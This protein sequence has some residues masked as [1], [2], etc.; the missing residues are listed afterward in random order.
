MRQ[1]VAVLTASL[2]ECTGLLRGCVAHA[3]NHIK[4]KIC[5]VT[6]GRLYPKW[7]DTVLEERH[8]EVGAE[9]VL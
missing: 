5:F 9:S 3:F 1:P 8:Y 7:L 6:L 2:K 4:R